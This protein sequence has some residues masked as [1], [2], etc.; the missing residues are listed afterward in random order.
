MSLCF[1][2]E[3]RKFLFHV[4]P[5]SSVNV[6]VWSEYCHRLFGTLFSVYSK[7]TAHPPSQRSYHTSSETESGCGV[8]DPWH[9]DLFCK[10]QAICKAETLPHQDCFCPSWANAFRCCMKAVPPGG[11]R[12]SYFSAS[13]ESLQAG[14]EEICRP[15]SVRTNLR[16]GWVCNCQSFFWGLAHR[17]DWAFLHYRQCVLVNYSHVKMRFYLGTWFN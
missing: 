6:T 3:Q 12:Q 11:I 9:T 13:Q 17:G 16:L 4:S 8:I 15:Y 2:L 1:T 10:W 5:L 7:V 14:A